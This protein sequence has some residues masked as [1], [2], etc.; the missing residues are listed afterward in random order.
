MQLQALSVGHCVDAGETGVATV[1]SVFARAVNIEVRGDL[2]TLLGAERADLPF[3]I[4]VAAQDFGAFGLRRGDCVHVRSGF[5]GIASDAARL[6]VDC[7]AAPRWIP[8]LPQGK[9]APGLRN[10]LR[11]VAAAASDRAWHGSDG[12]AR[13]VVS[14]LDEPDALAEVLAKVVGRGPGSTPAGD[15]VLVGILAVLASPQSGTPGARAVQSLCRPLLRLLP[16]TTDISGHLLRQAANGLFSR[17][18]HELVCALI[19]DADLQQLRDTVQR[20]VETGATSGADLCTG[21]LASAPLLL[22]H[23]GR[24]AF[25]TCDAKSALLTQDDR[26]AA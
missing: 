6:V 23:D 15:D 7:R 22:A 8:K 10:R 16:T 3:G 19:G 13:A 26:A 9:P 24:A 18:V 21:M 11:M 4:R 12:M 2:W 17:A 14:A 25:L 5:V 20:V 1:H